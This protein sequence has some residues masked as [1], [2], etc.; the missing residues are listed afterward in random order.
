M[1]SYGHA[2]TLNQVLAISSFFSDSVTT[3]STLHRVLLLLP[4]ALVYPV[5]QALHEV[6]N[7]DV[8]SYLPVGQE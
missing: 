4:A 2:G 7:P 5:L 1:V 8:I 3:G 6:A